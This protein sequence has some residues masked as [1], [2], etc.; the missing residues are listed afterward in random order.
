MPLLL[1]EAA[2]ILLCRVE[3]PEGEGVPARAYEQEAEAQ[4]RAQQ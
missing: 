2:Y 4:E 1:Y 3:L